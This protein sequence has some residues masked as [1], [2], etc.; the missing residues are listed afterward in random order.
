MNNRLKLLILALG[1]ILLVG[2]VIILISPEIE[3]SVQ[4]QNYTVSPEITVIVTKTDIQPF[5]HPRLYY[6]PSELPSVK[7]RMDQTSTK[8]LW[9]SIQQYARNVN[10]FPPSFNGGE[11]IGDILNGLRY[12]SFTY[13]MTGDTTVL[14][15][16]N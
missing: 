10:Q 15:V 9:M 6:T 11:N 1:I 5:V 8:P 13:A 16:D 2:L 12:T 3:P 7:A 14:V 4:P